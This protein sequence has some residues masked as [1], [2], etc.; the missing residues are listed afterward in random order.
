[1]SQ[2]LDDLRCIAEG[3]RHALATVRT[4]APGFVRRLVIVGVLVVTAAAA[5]ATGSKLLARHNTASGQ[6][7]SIAVLPFQNISGDPSQEYLSD[8]MTD[9]LISS[10]AQI[11]ALDVISR[12][13]SMRFKGTRQ[14]IPEIGRAVGV[15]ALVE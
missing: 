1:M 3:R 15:D 7:R 13:S 10:L 12:T 2:V 8:G 5:A 6:I 11:H 9:A 4:R 14:S